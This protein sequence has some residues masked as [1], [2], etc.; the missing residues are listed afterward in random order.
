MKLYGKGH[1]FRQLVSK[2]APQG[3]FFFSIHH[4]IHH[5]QVRLLTLTISEC[6]RPNGCFNSDDLG[7][8]H[9]QTPY[10]LLT[11]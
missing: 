9:P 6:L 1:R 8:F 4:P 5:I 10:V 11:L 7:L 3:A 2:D